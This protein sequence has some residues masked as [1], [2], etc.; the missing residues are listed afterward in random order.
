MAGVGD[1]VWTTTHKIL[2]WYPVQSY[3]Q[4]EV[5]YKCKAQ[6]VFSLIMQLWEND[7]AFYFDILNIF[8]KLQVQEKNTTNGWTDG[9]PHRTKTYM[10]PACW[11]EE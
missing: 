7:S 11:V 3:G 10:A 9:Q 8:L 4:K 2:S 5:W 1:N 6:S